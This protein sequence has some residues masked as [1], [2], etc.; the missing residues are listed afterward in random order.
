MSVCACIWSYVCV[1]REKANVAKKKKK[2]RGTSARRPCEQHMSNH[3]LI[4]ATFFIDFKFSK[5]NLEGE[6]IFSKSLK[7]K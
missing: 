5:V 4:H 1:R 7:L 2:K 3:R 6:N